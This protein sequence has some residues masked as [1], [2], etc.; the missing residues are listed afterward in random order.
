MPPLLSSQVRL[1]DPTGAAEGPPPG[2]GAELAA[3]AQ[4]YVDEDPDG[5]AYRRYRGYEPLIEALRDKGVADDAM[6]SRAD[7]FG[8]D[9]PGT[10]S[11]DYAKIYDL[12]RRNGLG[13]LKANRGEFEAD[14]A[15]RPGYQ[16]RRAKVERGGRWWLELP[17][18]VVQSFQPE[19]GPLP[20][21]GLPSKTILGAAAREAAINTIF[22]GVEIAR[23]AQARD[24]LGN[25]ITGEEMLLRGSTA[26]LGGAIFGGGVKG[27]ELKAPGAIDGVRT[28][29][30]RL[31]ADNWDR[32]PAGL[33]EKWG[34]AANVDGTA[35]PDVFEAIVGRENM[36]LDE[37]GAVALLRRDAELEALNP[38]RPDGAGLAAHN[39]AVQ[40]NVERVAAEIEGM[41]RPR[42]AAASQGGDTAISTGVVRVPGQPGQL[43]YANDVYQYFRAKGV[44]D[45]VARGIA[46]GIHAES[47]SD[48][49]VRGGYKGRAVG[50]GQWLGP[51]R[52]RLIERYGPNPT[53]RQQLD[54]MWE[55]LQGGDPGGRS[56]L[57][58]GDEVAV[59]DAY[60]R[61]FM[62]PARGAETA[63]DLSRGMQA[64]GRGGETM[65]FADEGAGRAAN[66]DIDP[67]AAV[68]AELADR[69][70][71]IDADRDRLEAERVSDADTDPLELEATAARR[72]PDLFDIAPMAELKRELFPDDTSWRI[73]QAA[74]DAEA[75]G[76]PVP[77]IT[78]QSVWEEA[79]DTLIA[80]KDGE[81][82]GA[83]F[84]PDVGPI[85]VKWGMPPQGARQGFGLA[86]IV[87]KHPEVLDDLPAI[88]EAMDVVSRT[89]NRI[90]L[91]SPDHKAAVRLDWEGESQTWLLTAFRKDEGGRNAPP[92]RRTDVPG[93]VARDGSPA[94]GA[95]GDVADIAGDG[96][97]PSDLRRIATPIGVDA[98][99]THSSG[100]FTFDGPRGVFSWNPQEGIAN[101]AFPRRTRVTADD[102]RAELV[103]APRDAGGLTAAERASL[104]YD[105]PGLSDFVDPAGGGARL[106][107]DGGVHDLRAAIDAE[108]P[109]AGVAFAARDGADETIADVV[110]SIDA[111][112]AALAALRACL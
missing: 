24:T 80:A 9:V 39:A 43:G 87:D 60:I 78:R 29:F 91:E 4:I 48:H 64:L 41:M 33:R 108:D 73:A 81:V 47:R 102:V 26:A 92:R 63:G 51:R 49:A 56:V 100:F 107:L 18:G 111:E 75:M 65:R 14:V 6:M 62:R 76:L 89:D 35:L 36:S 21:L 17:L 37:K 66:D 85:D 79:R 40:R 50:L 95:A 61:K 83:L 13:D 34:S 99:G 82:P 104:D 27:V 110:A 8:V 69:Q 45:H 16:Q 70:R 20:A 109:I 74:V 68:R 101:G 71:G 112:E 23:T 5:V 38:F 54:F 58:A 42:A 59:L 96:N 52:A 28:R 97:M 105:E 90:Q 94:R 3:R 32:L 2:I 53:R 46:A 1:G 10:S 11:W 72:Q 88:L 30:E 7:V 86:K 98:D 77:A 19:Y 55:E 31:V 57:A 106:D 93:K 15:A 84:H 25:P 12:A 44:P 67:E 103:D 22:E